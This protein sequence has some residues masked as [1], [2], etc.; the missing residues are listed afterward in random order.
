[1]FINSGTYTKSSFQKNQKQNKITNLNEKLGKKISLNKSLNNLDEV[2]KT[3]YEDNQLTEK[4]L[5]KLLLQKISS[6]TSKQATFG[7]INQSL[8]YFNE[9][10]SKKSNA[11]S[12]NQ[13][14]EARNGFK[15][16]NNIY[17]NEQTQRCDENFSDGEENVIKNI[18][19][20]K[21]SM[22]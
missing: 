10:D 20:Q 17:S 16:L 15:E 2:N 4:L 1:L 7:N 19:K 21:K 3:D 6:H 11:S 14:N 8:K 9:I 13:T 18:S 5:L 22:L 12:R